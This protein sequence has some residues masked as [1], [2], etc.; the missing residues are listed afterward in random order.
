MFG[1][2]IYRFWFWLYET[3][4]Y[5]ISN[6]RAI[7]QP[8]GISDIELKHMSMVQNVQEI[9]LIEVKILR[10]C[11]CSS[12]E[13]FKVINLNQ[14]NCHYGVLYANPV[15][16]V[17]LINCLDIHKGCYGTLSCFTFFNGRKFW[18]TAT[19]IFRIGS[20]SGN[21]RMVTP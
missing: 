21:V 12:N 1:V 16:L 14:T 13:Q 8:Q 3:G 20:R 19:H 7:H 6:F 9:F 11:W 2:C 17:L 4:F 15:L 18:L 10:A 5:M